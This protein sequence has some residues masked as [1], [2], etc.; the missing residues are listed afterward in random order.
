M[1]RS[2]LLGLAAAAITSFATAEP[3]PVILKDGASWTL[4]VE[5]S[6][7]TQQPD[8]SDAWTVVTT[9]RLDWRALP[10]GG[11][12]LTVTPLSAIPSPDSPPEVAKAAALDVSVVLEVDA[13]LTPTEVVNMEALRAAFGR[14]TGTL[15]ASAASPL[16]DLADAAITTLAT[17]D[18][19]RLALAQDS[20]LKIGK[21]VAYE[22][23]SPNPLGGPP[24]KG[25]GEVRL[26]SVNR[27]AGVAVI[28]WRYEFDPQSAATS[29]ATSLQLMLA[30][31]PDAKKQE[32]AKVFASLSVERH[33]V[34]SYQV[35]LSTGLVMLA[36]CEAEVV[37]TAASQ[38][39]KR[40]DR[41]LFTQTA[42]EP[43]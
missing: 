40:T 33:E 4:K 8:R 11:G 19:A 14:M 38:T 20:D 36:R 16:S 28:G 24:I 42:P 32:A 13:A 7:Q 9:S 21:A 2:V 17:Q 3:I 37:S 27:K 43:R 26:E 10:N 29:V 6:R 41:W 31:V 18:I 12:R 35:S 23:E 34:C 22:D 30:K 15:N 5:H 1:I 39:R 25:I